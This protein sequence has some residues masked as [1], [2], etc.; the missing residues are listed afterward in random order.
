MTVQTIRD[1]LKLESASGLLLIGAMLLAVLCANTPLSWLYDGFL[2]TRFEIHFGAL[3]LAKPL[4]L[5]I[6]DGLMAIFFLLVGLEVKREILEGELSSLP[7]IALPGIAA[8]GGMLVPA[9]IYTGINWSAPATLQGWAIPAATDIAF[10]LGV[11]A[12]LGKNV[13]GPLKLFLLTLAILD[14]LGA[15]V[16]IALFYTADL[17]VLSLVLAMIA[18]AGLF[19]LN[20]TGVTHIAAYVLLGVFLWICVLKSGVHATLAGVVLAFAIPLRTK[21]QDGHSLL[22]HLEHTLHP[23][24]A[25]GILPIFAFANAG[26]SLAG[27]S[28]TDV[29]S[30]LPLGI[31]AGL[32]VGKQFGIVVFSWIGVKLRMARLP[33]GV[34]WGEFHGMAVLCGIGFT[35]S[36]FIATLALDGSQ[37]TADAARLGVLLG[38]LMSA[39]SGYYLLKRAVRKRALRAEAP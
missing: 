38:S 25:Y 31:A 20:R 16:I 1:F 33:Q 21:D 22:R 5:W 13:P 14:D 10:A 9:L 36:L 39:L 11:I 19:I 34:S 32:F 37:E 18:V 30:P 6:N 35:M 12:L 29:F 17:S 28:F 24:V 27:I 4:L 3:S 23:W 15:I 26:V 7:Q 2:Q 8:V